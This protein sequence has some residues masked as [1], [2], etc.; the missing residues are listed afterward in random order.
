MK[1][2]IEPTTLVIK[3]K[4]DTSA[5]FW[6]GLYLTLGVTLG[7]CIAGVAV[8]TAAVICKFFNW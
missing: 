6:I 4:K 2:E 5:Y 3:T 8:T 1:I 7:I